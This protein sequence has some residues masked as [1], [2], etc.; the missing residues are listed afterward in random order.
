MFCHTS[1]ELSDHMQKHE[2]EDHTATASKPLA[3]LFSPRKKA[4]GGAAKEKRKK[5]LPVRKLLEL[6]RGSVLNFKSRPNEEAPNGEE[7]KAPVSPPEMSKEDQEVKI[8]DEGPA[9]DKDDSAGS[10]LGSLEQMVEKSFGPKAGKKQERMEYDSLALSLLTAHS[11]MKKVTS[12]SQQHSLIF[13]LG[14][15]FHF[16][17]KSL[18]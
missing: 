12:S 6:E 17:K 8:L 18:I 9:A 1:K 11:Q 13:L 2:E 15:F 5:S 4:T 16:K 14:C 7:E 10:I 3:N